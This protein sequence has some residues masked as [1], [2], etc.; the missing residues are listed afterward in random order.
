M[1]G[2]RSYEEYKEKLYDYVE[3]RTNLVRNLNNQSY[4]KTRYAEA[5]KYYTKSKKT[6]KQSSKQTDTKKSN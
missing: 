4:L 5:S 3:R 6:S 1:F 2:E